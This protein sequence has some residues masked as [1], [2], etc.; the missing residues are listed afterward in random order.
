MSGRKKILLC[1]ASGFIG[2]N[3][4]ERLSANSGYEVT[5]VHF[6][7]DLPA[8]FEKK[9]NVRFV[10]ADLTRS[11][12]VERV[13]KGA[14][15]LIQA[16]ATTSG[17][18]DIVNQ[19][20]Y[21]VTDNAVMNALLFRACHDFKVGQVVFFSCTTMYQSQEYPVREEDFNG[22]ITDKYFGVG[23][24]KVYN[25]KM[26]EFYARTGTTRYTVLRHSNIYGPHDKFDLEKS[27]VF[28]AS[29]A[30]VMSCRG[31]KVRV[32]GDGSDERDLLHVDDLCDAVCLLLEKQT[33]P[34]ELLNV[35]LG[36][37][38]S[39]AELV[40][41]IIDLSGRNLE[42]EFDRSQPSIG[43]K[44]AV[45]IDKIQKRYGWNPKISLDEGIR[46][47]LRWYQ[48]NYGNGGL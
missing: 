18:K 32:W 19:P 24:T 16:A 45:N 28:G 17:A 42:I 48:E 11:E 29:V 41:K 33:E 37:S 4:L 3:L 22:E 8:D 26:C 39:V 30:K 13:V 7:R 20:H 25:E 12:D 35:G 46:K 2:R 31:S 1:G 9:D 40:K 5:A 6:R 36:R 15:V 10:R 47:T 23:W 34:F 43:F 21:H 44:L 27:H 38:V 14:D